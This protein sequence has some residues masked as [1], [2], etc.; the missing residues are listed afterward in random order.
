MWSERVALSDGQWQKEFWLGLAM[1]RVV[2]FQDLENIANLRCND[3]RA[4]RLGGYDAVTLNAALD[5]G[6]VGDEVI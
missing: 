3:I 4:E 1:K 6:L 2:V 5:T